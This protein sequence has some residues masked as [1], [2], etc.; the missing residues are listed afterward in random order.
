MAPKPGDT[1]RVHYKGTLADGNVFDSSE[2][3]EPLG[4]TVGAGEVIPG[5]DAAVAELEIGQSVTVTIPVANAYGEKVPELIQPVPLDFFQG[6]TPEVGWAIQLASPDGN[7]M[8]AIVA[9]VG[10][11]EVVLDL[12]HPLS[13]QDLTFEIELVEIIEG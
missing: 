13:G 3:R 1:V 9:A 8:M 11:D 4:F 7:T 12:N 5:F 6:E 2:G 10:D